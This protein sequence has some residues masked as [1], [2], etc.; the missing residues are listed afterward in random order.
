MARID[1]QLAD[2]APAVAARVAWRITPS[3]Y[4][5]CT[6]DMTIHADLQRR[7][8]QRCTASVEWPT[9]H[10]PFI[11]RPDLVAALLIE[12]VADVAGAG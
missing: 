6:D 8:A 3:T 4:A 7:L 1:P 10:S 2:L 12:V 5:V 11:S 9:G